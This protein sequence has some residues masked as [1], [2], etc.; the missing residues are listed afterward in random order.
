MDF[1]FVTL[2]LLFFSLLSGCAQLETIDR[3]EV[4]RPSMSLAA[5]A[6][7]QAPAPLTNLKS[8]SSVEVG[9]CTVCSH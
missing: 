1:K 3:S 8:N 5:G 9:S 7:I 4:N 6:K 2:F